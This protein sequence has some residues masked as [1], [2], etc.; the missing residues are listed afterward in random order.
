MR[1]A[2]GHIKTTQDIGDIG[3]GAALAAIL[4]VAAIFALA[5]CLKAFPIPDA[6]L[7]VINQVIKVGSVAAGTLL[8]V[9]R[10]GECGFFKGAATGTIYML[11]GIALYQLLGGEGSTLLG[12]L[13]DVLLGGASGGIAGILS[14]N[15]RPGK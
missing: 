3:K 1:A 12:S 4:S 8:C 5:L 13:C 9:G 6:L 2:L 10:G 14:A 15:L 7:A 11:L